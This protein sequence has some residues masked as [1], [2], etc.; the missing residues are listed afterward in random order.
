M[1]FHFYSFIYGCPLFST[2]LSLHILMAT[3]RRKN[4][5]K[6]AQFDLTQKGH[7]IEGKGTKNNGMECLRRWNVILIL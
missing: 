4:I 1:M 3:M 7:L 6:V 2:L 5:T